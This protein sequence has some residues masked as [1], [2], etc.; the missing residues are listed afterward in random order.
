MTSLSSSS[1]EQLYMRSSVYGVDTHTEGLY[2][3][4][5]NSFGIYDLMQYMRQH[6]DINNNKKDF[7]TVLEKTIGVSDF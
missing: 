6:D 4:D 7:L 1:T 3:I 5:V 2:Q